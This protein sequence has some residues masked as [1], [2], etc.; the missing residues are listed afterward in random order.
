MYMLLYM[1]IYT[2][3]YTYICAHTH[4]FIG[5][6]WTGAKSNIKVSS[7]SCDNSADDCTET[8][9]W[10]AAVFGVSMWNRSMVYRNYSCDHP[11]KLIE[12]NLLAVLALKPE[13]EVVKK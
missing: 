1:H 9:R 3:I 2:C 6:W 4:I 11:N 7:P 13:N 8:K 12:F 10:T 5:E